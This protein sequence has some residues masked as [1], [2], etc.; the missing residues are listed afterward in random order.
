VVSGIALGVATAA[1][2]GSADFLARYATRTIG[3][4]RALFWMHVW[5]TVFVT[6]LLLFVHDWGHLF[7]GS[8]WQPWGWGI[9]AG[10]TNVLAMLALYRSFEIGKLSIVGPV[11]ASYPALTVFLSILSGESLTALRG[12]GILAA[13]GGVLLVSRGANSHSD[14]QVKITAS[15]STGVGWAIAASILF[16]F[17]FWLLGIRIIPRTGALA[18]VWLLRL[19]GAIVTFI[20]VLSARLPL[21]MTNRQTTGRLYSMGFLDTAAFAA[22]N[23]GMRI[24]QV[25]IVTV[26]GSLYGAVTVAWAA[27]FLKERISKLQWAGIAFIF[28][29]V[30]LINI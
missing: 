23:L 10:V 1:S 27:L 12:A 29:G 11:S 16:G 2:W 17:V 26:L 9:L 13:L 6:L 25:S 22:S 5:G 14:S 18:S 24:E 7:D 30:T 28:L 4:L 3:S 8:G 19:S 21:G 15:G 20:L